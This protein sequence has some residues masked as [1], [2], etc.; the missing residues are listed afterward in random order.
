M[1]ALLLLLAGSAFL[2]D[3]DLAWEPPM[4]HQGQ[5]IKHYHIYR[6]DDGCPVSTSDAIVGVPLFPAQTYV[7]AVP[8]PGAYCWAATSVDQE[9]DE[10]ILSNTANLT[11]TAPGE[12]PGTAF[13]V[14]IVPSIP[15]PDS[16][17]VYVGWDSQSIPA[18]PAWLTDDYTDMG[19]QACLDSGH[20]FNLWERPVSVGVTE[21]PGNYYSTITADHNY[22]AFSSHELTG[23]PLS[24]GVGQQVYRDRAHVLSS[25]PAGFC[26][27]IHKTNADDRFSSDPVRE[28]LDLSSNKVNCN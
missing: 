20:C 5:G 3:V 6:S 9:D 19:G 13:I 14:G 25:I 26:A 16:A 21:I 17:K 1:N 8:G 7:D 15:E 23:E 22:I 12:P 18:A 4:Q 11:I 10:S 2:L 28:S 24:V 27:T